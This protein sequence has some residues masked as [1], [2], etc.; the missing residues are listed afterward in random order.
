MNLLL[1]RHTLTPSVS[2]GDLYI[3]G[4]RFCHTLED[5][6]REPG[7]PKVPGRTAIPVGQYKVKLTMSPRFKMIMPLLEGN[8]EFTKNWSGV[9]IHTGN[10]DT[11]TEG[12]ILV[13]F[14]ING[15]RLEQSLPAYKALVQQLT[16]VEDINLEIANVPF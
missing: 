3:N 7:Q 9:R 8:E 5:T 16:G 12:C 10:S 2:L 6:Y 1:C 11:D 4:A 13:G 15:S 14:K